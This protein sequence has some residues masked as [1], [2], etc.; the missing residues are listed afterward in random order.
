MK[1]IGFTSGVFDMFHIGH[2]NLINNA[3]KQCDYLIVGVNSDELMQSYKE[4]YPVIPFAERIAIVAALRNVDETIRVDTLDKESIWQ[5]KPFDLLFIG[6]DWKGTPRWN[7][8]ERVM[9]THNVKTIY[10][11]YTGNTNSTLLREKLIM[12]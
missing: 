11:P 7:E 9:L 10:L 8:T 4:K 6:D 3:K 5:I 2:L 1:K 12:R